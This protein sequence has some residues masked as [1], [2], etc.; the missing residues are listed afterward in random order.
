M[1]RTSSELSPD[2][3][4]R[5]LFGAEQRRYR[6]AAGMT[7]E[8]LASVVMSSRSQLSRVETAQMMIPRELPGL[9]D[10]VFGTD[11]I[12][13]R[14]YGVARREAHPDRYRRRM[15]LEMRA[16]R[17]DW[18]AG[19]LVPGLLQTE[20][21]ALALFESYSPRKPR[22]KFDEIWH[23][24]RSRQAQLLGEDAPRLLAILDEAVVR[25]PIGGGSVMR[26]QLE[27]LV[28]NVDAPNCLIQLLPFAHGTHPLAGGTL[29]LLT[30][31]DDSV[32]AY[33]ENIST[34]QL[35]EDVESTTLASQAYDR[36]RAYALSPA[37][38]AA[39]I[40]EAMKGLPE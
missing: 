32:V 17:I 31:D 12:F 21:Y 40:V 35:L 29:E 8:Q 39:F 9:L 15:E 3:S 30:L 5:H 37:D 1:G 36:I 28:E 2:R 27:L 33:E 23:A 16:K 20:E 7:L 14:M 6:E 4:A 34:G 24:R 38:T 25:R 18:Y 11:G 26:A 10:A 13:G 19:L 22:E